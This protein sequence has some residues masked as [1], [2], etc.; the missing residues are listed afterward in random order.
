MTT[1]VDTA[2]S[3]IDAAI[4]DPGCRQ[5]TQPVTGSPS[6]D[7]CSEDCQQIWH[8][9]QTAASEAA[10]DRSILGPAQPHRWAGWDSY[11][12]RSGDPDWKYS[13]TSPRS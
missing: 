1:E 11:P 7:F 8:E 4:G 10:P 5:C 12:E 6:T 3:A 9:Q 13:M 2:V